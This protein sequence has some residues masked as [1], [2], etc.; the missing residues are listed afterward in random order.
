[1]IVIVHKDRIASLFVKNLKAISLVFGWT[2]TD[3]L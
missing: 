1:M 2:E 3:E